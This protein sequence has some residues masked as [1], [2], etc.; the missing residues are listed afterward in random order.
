[1]YRDLKNDIIINGK[2]GKGY[3]IGKGVKQ[4]DALSCSLF[5]LAIEPVIRNINNNVT[6]TPIHNERIA[7]TWPKVVAYADDIT[8]ISVNSSNSVKAIFKEYERLTLASGLKL[9]DDK[10]ERFDITGRE[11]DRHMANYAHE[12]EYCGVRHIITPLEQVKI[13]GILFH[14]NKRTMAELN[15]NTM[16]DKM[17]RHFNNWSRRSLSLLGKIQIIKTFGL[18]QYLYSLAVI[19]LE[20]DHWTE[21]NKLINKFIWNKHFSPLPAPHRIKNDIIH[22]KLCNGGFGMIRLRSVNAATRL[23]RC[24]KLAEQRIHP[25]WALQAAF[26]MDCHLQER[27]LLNIVDVTSDV[28]SR[29]RKLT[30]DAYSKIPQEVAL[31]D[32]VLH[33]KLLGCKIKNLIEPTK[34]LSIEYA[35]L[36]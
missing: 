16:K 35:R 28:I 5:L 13:N 8:V 12:I 33:K 2:I 3:S 34:H 4:G 26:R 14:T 6:I 20:E 1:M 31:A 24:A 9:N 15:F 21:V 7:Y 32:L 30:L 36:Q 11:V 22:R 23:K 19:D 27:P 18:S 10:T 29:L 17:V 25:V